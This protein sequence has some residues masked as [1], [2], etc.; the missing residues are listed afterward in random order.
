MTSFDP[1][2]V[3]VG[4]VAYGLLAALLVGVATRK[5]FAGA[6]GPQY[7]SAE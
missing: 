5:A 3:A 2:V 6:R 1:V 7:R 4:L